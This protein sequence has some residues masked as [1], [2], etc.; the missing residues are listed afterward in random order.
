[1]VIHMKDGSTLP[2][3]RTLIK[4]LATASPEQSAN[5]RSMDSAPACGG[6]SWRCSFGS[7]PF[8]RGFTDGQDGR[9]IL[10]RGPNRMGDVVQP[11]KVF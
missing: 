10:Q 7:R 5:G 6:L 1:M 3:P 11:I 2:V 4:G 9:V 8:R